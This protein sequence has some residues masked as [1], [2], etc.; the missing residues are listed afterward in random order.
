VIV[1]QVFVVFQDQRISRDV[2]LEGRN[3]P[4][5]KGGDQEYQEQGRDRFAK[6]QSV[7]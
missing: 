3:E 6:Y 7:I 1:A 4:A 2:D 5:E